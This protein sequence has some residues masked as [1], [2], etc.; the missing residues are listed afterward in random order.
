TPPV[1]YDPVYPI[2]RVVLGERNNYRFPQ[3]GRWMGMTPAA[4]SETD[5][6]RNAVQELM[7]GSSAAM[8]QVF[9]IIGLVGP[10][11]CTVLI[12]GETGTGKEMAARAIHASS[13]RSRQ[14]MVTV[15]CAALPENL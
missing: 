10:R 15:N 5:S 8:E 1:Y 3:S 11:R 6:R 13:G 7:V 2:L 9:R 14:S 12:H 4:P